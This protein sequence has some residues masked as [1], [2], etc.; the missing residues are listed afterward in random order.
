[1]SNVRTGEIWLAELDPTVGHEQGGRRPVV[2]V[3][4][5]GLHALPINMVMVVPLTGHDR[6]LVT[7]PRIS[8]PE[9][10]LRRVSFARPEDLRA[11]DATRLRRRLGQ[12]TTDELAE[13]RKVMRYF[14]D[15]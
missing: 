4:S 8:G 9:T 14:L 6:G 2:V 15:L 7:Q 5:N 11:I 12:I 3:S 10:G 1:M 13:I